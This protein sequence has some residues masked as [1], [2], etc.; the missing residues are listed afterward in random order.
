[1]RPV[2]PWDL[3]RK[4]NWTEAE[5]YAKRLEIC[6]ECSHFTK[7]RQCDLCYC[8]MDMKTRLENA[9]CPIRKW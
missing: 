7:T 5:V 9:Y 8:F 3:L 1:M 2:K 4:E 6:E